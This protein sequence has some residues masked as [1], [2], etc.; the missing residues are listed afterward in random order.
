MSA[1][2]TTPVSTMIWRSPLMSIS[3]TPS[4]PRSPFGST[5]TTRAVSAAVSEPERVVLPPPWNSVL[6]FAATR[7]DGSSQPGNFDSRPNRFVTAADALLF[8]SSD[9]SADPCAVTSSTTWTVTRSLTR[10]ARRSPF[11]PAIHSESGVG[12]AGAVRAAAR[13][14]WNSSS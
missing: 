8:L 1:V 6:A 2:R 5:S 7:L 9:E 13:Y 11:R 14:C 3:R 10:R 12:V 4:S